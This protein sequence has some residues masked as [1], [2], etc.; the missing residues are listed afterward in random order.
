VITEGSLAPL[1]LLQIYLSV[2]LLR[3]SNVNTNFY[4]ILLMNEENDEIKVF[5]FGLSMNF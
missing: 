3:F 2:E 1:V 5:G 4:L